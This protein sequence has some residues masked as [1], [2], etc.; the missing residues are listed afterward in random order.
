[1]E[2]D[3]PI[4][5]AQKREDRER[6]QILEGE[7]FRIIRFTNDQV[8]NSLTDVL[9][10]IKKEVLKYLIRKNKHVYKGVLNMFIKEF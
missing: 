4:H 3:G 1:V 10:K 7:G 8:L 9:K 5:E 6:E 2:V